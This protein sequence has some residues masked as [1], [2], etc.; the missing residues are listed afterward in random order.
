[1]NAVKLIASITVVLL[2]TGCVS[3]SPYPSWDTR[4][5]SV[6]WCASPVGS[7]TSAPLRSTTETKNSGQLELKQ[8]FFNKALNGFE[9]THLTFNSLEPDIVIVKPW[10][11]ERMLKEEVRIDRRSKKCKEGRWRITSDWE[12]LP[13][14]AMAGLL[15]TGGIL[16]PMA[17]R[18]TFE[19]EL[20]DTGDLVVHA[21]QRTSGTTFLFFPMRTRDADEWFL[22]KKTGSL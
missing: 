6:D 3:K 14:A 1:M 15:W 20:T 5:Q 22:Y 19:L 13:G 4:A 16:M 2:T 11:G 10:I 17:S 8:V 9:V 21:V 7:F 18:A 12:A